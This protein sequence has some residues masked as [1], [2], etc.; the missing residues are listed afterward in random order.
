V[1]KRQTSFPA[2]FVN[3]YELGAKTTWAGGTLLL[4]AT[5]FHQEYQDFQ[6]NSFLGTSFVVRSIPEVTSTGVDAEVLWQPQAVSGLMLQGGVMY[7]R[8]RLGDDI[9]GVDF[10]QRTPL[11]SS[12]ALY[13]LPG[14]T[15]PFAPEWSGSLSAT[16]E[17]DFANSLEGRFNIGAKYMGAYNTGSDL[18]VEKRQSAYTVA[19][20]RLGVGAADGRW[21]VE[22]WGTNITDTDYVQ[23]GFDAPLQG[24]FPDP[25]NP[26]NT[27]NAFPGAPRMYGVTLRLHY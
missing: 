2:E 21:V 5:A 25:G 10:Q 4:N 27:F 19:N 16:Y 3:S 7:A 15:M 17:W 13:K 26:L 11:S 9:P 24:L 6:L 1:Y 20:A 22:L 12:G 8:T 23:V 14:A 18:D